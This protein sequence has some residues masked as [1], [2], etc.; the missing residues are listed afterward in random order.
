MAEIVSHAS[1]I[2]GVQEMDDQHG[3]LVDSL[4]AIGQQLRC[5]KS[6]SKLTEQIAR[7]VEFTDLHFG[8][9]ESLLLRY[10]FPGLDEHHKAHRNLM[11]QIK[12]AARRAE[13]AQNAELEQMLTAIRGQYLRH[14]EEL[15]REYG[16]WLNA[17]G[18][19]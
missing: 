15:D 7:L 3:I 14:V 2:A 11:N 19:Y 1:T 9:E 12:L 17:H 16:R 8:C 10:D 4:S 18:V 5:G 13:H 6:G